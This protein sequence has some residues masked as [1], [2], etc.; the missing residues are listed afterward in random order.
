MSVPYEQTK[1][2]AWPVRRPDVLPSSG[3]VS[4][5]P[6]NLL[7]AGLSSFERYRE[8]LELVVLPPHC[9]L[10]DAGRSTPSVYFPET[11]VLAESVPLRDGSRVAINL[12]G[13]EGAADLA[14]CLGAPTV[15]LEL[16]TV[17]GGS[18]L[19]MPAA[20]FVRLARDDGE[21]LERLHLYDQ[22]LLNVRAYAVACS[23]LHTVQARLTRLLLRVHEQANGEDFVLT[24]DLIAELLG[25]SR[26]SVTVNAIMFQRHGLI[27]YRRGRIRILN[28]VGLEAMACECYW[29][30]GAEYSRLAG[31]APVDDALTH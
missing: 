22:I 17:V 9:L 28:R 15:P 19:R 27:E 20:T 1:R 29:V 11:G 12:V 21:M 4:A 23:R 5:G 25:V 31:G 16:T 30:I 24:H 18:F 8:R 14:A 3:L 26:P 7:V 6:R 2:A 10:I 13:H